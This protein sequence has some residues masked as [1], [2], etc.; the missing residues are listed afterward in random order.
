MSIEKKLQYIGENKGI[1]SF[2]TANPKAREGFDRL[3][4]VS[5]PFEDRTDVFLAQ[6]ALFSDTDAYEEKAERVSLMTLH[7]AKGGQERARSQ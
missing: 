3:I 5:I 2:L 4:S 1:R 6:I 7:A